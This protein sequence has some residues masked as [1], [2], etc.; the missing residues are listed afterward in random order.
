MPDF[1]R[2]VTVSSAE[3]DEPQ[4]SSASDHLE[5]TVKRELSVACRLNAA[6]QPAVA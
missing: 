3:Q 4:L 5:A 2:T 6:A 1:G